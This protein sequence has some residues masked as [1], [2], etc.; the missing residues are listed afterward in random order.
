MEA[1]IEQGRHIA[2]Q[3]KYAT[4]KLELFVANVCVVRGVGF[5][6]NLANGSRYRAGKAYCSLSKICK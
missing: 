3:V 2:H 1:N 6:K 5:Q 4:T